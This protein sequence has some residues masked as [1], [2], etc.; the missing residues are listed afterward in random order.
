MSEPL[1]KT[2]VQL[3]AHSPFHCLDT[4]TQAH[5][6]RSAIEDRRLSQSNYL[7][8]LDYDS[9]LPVHNRPRDSFIIRRTEWR[10]HLHLNKSFLCSHLHIRALMGRFRASVKAHIC[11]TALTWV[12]FSSERVRPKCSLLF[13]INWPQTQSL[14]CPLCSF[15]L[16]PRLAQ[17]KDLW[18][19]TLCTQPAFSWLLCHFS[20]IRLFDFFFL[21]GGLGDGMLFVS[22]MALRSGTIYIVARELGP[23]DPFVVDCM[24]VGWGQ[25]WGGCPFISLLEEGLVPTGAPGSY[26][27]MFTEPGL[28]RARVVVCVC[29]SPCRGCT[30]LTNCC[31][32]NLS[33]N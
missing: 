33:N 25:G 30:I 31:K 13:R 9:S 21:G 6:L 24:V 22:F 7:Q 8:S 26:E 19:S 27:V 20:S 2:A 17:T 12:S 32:E 16:F 23:P 15:T 1:D 5:S 4:H 3:S 28:E 10:P 11:L 29:V 18:P 14:T